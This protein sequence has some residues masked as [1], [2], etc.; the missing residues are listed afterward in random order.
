MKR[1]TKCIRMSGR[2][3]SNERRMKRNKQRRFLLKLEMAIKFAWNVC[4]DEIKS[5][6]FQYF[7]DGVFRH[8][9]IRLLFTPVDFWVAAYHRL[10]FFICVLQGMSLVVVALFAS[11]SATILSRFRFHLCIP[12][13]IFWHHFIVAL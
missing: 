12:S 8:C 5:A 4:V 13:S 2:N 1:K 11:V 3:D 6:K 10:V 9:M 7:D